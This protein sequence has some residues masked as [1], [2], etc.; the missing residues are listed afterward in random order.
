MHAYIRTQMY[1]YI[2]RAYIHAN[3]DACMLIWVHAYTFIDK[4]MLTTVHTYPV[5]LTNSSFAMLWRW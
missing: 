4:Y 2:H 3:M 5:R 1:T